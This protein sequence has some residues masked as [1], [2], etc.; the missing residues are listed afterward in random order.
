[1]ENSTD[2][3]SRPLGSQIHLTSNEIGNYIDRYLGSH[4]GPSLHGIEGMTIG[5]LSANPNGSLTSKD[6]VEHFHISKPTASQTLHRLE[7][8]GLITH[9]D[10]SK[11]RRIKRIVLTPKG[12]ARHQKFEACLAVITATL[13]KDITPEERNTLSFVLN[14]I[15]GNIH[16]GEE[17][18]DQNH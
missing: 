15:I 13:E 7:K 5:Y 16:S 2:F 14:K 10:D 4:L 18:H 3:S 6:V 1:M 8:K 12:I 17:D 11:D 9:H